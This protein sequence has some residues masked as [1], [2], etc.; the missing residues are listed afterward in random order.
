MDTSVSREWPFGALIVGPPWSLALLPPD[1]DRTSSVEDGFGTANLAL[2]ECGL[3]LPGHAALPRSGRALGFPRY[4]R[5]QCQTVSRPGKYPRRDDVG[6]G[7]GS[8]RGMLSIHQTS[9]ESE[10]SPPLSRRTS[11]RC[12]VHV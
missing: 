8:Q 7:G 2:W 9:C 10:D 5:W 1:A 6:P 4:S 3:D 12:F 11:V